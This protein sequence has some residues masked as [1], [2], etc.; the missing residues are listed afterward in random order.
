MVFNLFK[1]RAPIIRPKAPLLKLEK[2][3][4]KR[5][6][7]VFAFF[8]LLGKQYSN[9]Y[10]KEHKY[11]NRCGVFCL[12]VF[13]RY[14]FLFEINGFIL[15]FILAH[16]TALTLRGTP[17]CP[18]KHLKAS[19]RLIYLTSEPKSALSGSFCDSVGAH[20]WIWGQSWTIKVAYDP[21]LMSSS[22]VPCVKSAQLLVLNSLLCFDIL[23]RERPSIKQ[24]LLLTK[25]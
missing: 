13:Y 24:I 6:L 2:P 22:C 12:F 21:L 5:Q 10:C 16:L 25:A 20:A 9:F 15:W 11:Y 3:H 14:G 8:R 23:E 4:R 1:P 17:Q 18:W 19:L 7:L